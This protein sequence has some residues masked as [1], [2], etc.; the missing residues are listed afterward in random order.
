MWACLDQHSADGADKVGMVVPCMW[1]SGAWCK[2][3]VRW[4]VLLGLKAFFAVVI[5]V[6]GPYVRFINV[7]RR[8]FVYCLLVA[9]WAGLSGMFSVRVVTLGAC[10]WGIGCSPCRISVRATCVG[11]FGVFACVGPFLFGRV[12]AVWASVSVG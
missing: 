1:A 5:M 3:G 4:G 6:S 9:G 7:S 12:V 8:T 11:A 10:I 2:G